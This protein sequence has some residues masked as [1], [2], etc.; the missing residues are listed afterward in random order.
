MHSR[1]KKRR[2]TQGTAF[3]TAK[4]RESAGDAQDLHA[5]SDP[6]PMIG[7]RNLKEREFTCA[8]R[9]TLSLR[10][11]NVPITLD[12]ERCRPTP[13]ERK[14][15]REPR[16]GGN[17]HCSSPVWTDERGGSCGRLLDQPD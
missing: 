13:R 6:R 9:T 8:R 7:N 3:L 1:P 17:A 12:E 4:Q 2:Q 10:I 5:L 16:S 15:K 14:L 11:Y